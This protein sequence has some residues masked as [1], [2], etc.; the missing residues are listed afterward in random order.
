MQWQLNIGIR[1]AFYWLDE[2]LS[3]SR[4]SIDI[5][6]QVFYHT[7]VRMYYIRHQIFLFATKYLQYLWK[8]N[9]DG[10]CLRK[11]SPESH[12]CHVFTYIHSLLIEKDVCDRKIFRLSFHMFLHVP[13]LWR[14]LQFLVRVFP[15]HS[16]I[17]CY[18][19]L[20]TFLSMWSII[21]LNYI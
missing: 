12:L 13:F 14:S 1:T 21:S 2:F 16:L 5:E 18:S 9:Y 15:F 3:I 10:V 11:L 4:I 8:E 6:V 20:G 17:L 7:E 19:Y